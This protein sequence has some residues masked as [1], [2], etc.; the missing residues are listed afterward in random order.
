MKINEN[1]LLNEILD[2]NPDPTEIFLRHGL[3]CLGCPG[4]QSE[5]LKEAAEGHGIDL[6]KLIDDLNEFL[7][8]K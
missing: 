4:A 7:G 1:M 8:D 5:N 2:M 3:N 6:A